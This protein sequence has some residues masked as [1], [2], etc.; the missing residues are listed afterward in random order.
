MEGD[1]VTDVKLE[2][3]DSFFGQM[4]EYGKKYAFLPLLN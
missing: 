3:P 1:K 4:M 2:Y